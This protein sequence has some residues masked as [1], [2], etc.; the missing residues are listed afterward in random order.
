MRRL[1]AY[2][3][4]RIFHMTCL[5]YHFETLHFYGHNVSTS[6]V[7]LREEE[8][9]KPKQTKQNLPKYFKMIITGQSERVDPRL[10]SPDMHKSS[11]SSS[12]STSSVTSESVS[13]TQT[14]ST[15]GKNVSDRFEARIQ[16]SPS[17]SPLSSSSSSSS[18]A[19][20]SHSYIALISMAILSYP[21]KKMVLSDIYQY[22]MDNFPYYNE[23]NK[24][25]KTNIRRNLSVNEC[26]IRIGRADGGKG[27]YW[28]ILPAYVDRFAKGVSRRRV[29]QSVARDVSGFNTSAQ[30]STTTR[31]TCP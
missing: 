4:S 27:N 18:S 24:A 28:S 15:F 5:K 12:E 11:V 23:E 2:R 7:I 17:T 1:I 14:L 26:F 21:G 31:A 3:R 8:K 20:R 13:V 6:L 10:D 30:A 9:N 19:K 25:L 29:H 16:S 22:I